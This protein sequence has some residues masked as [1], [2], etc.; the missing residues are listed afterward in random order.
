MLYIHNVR[1]GIRDTG[2]GLPAGWV[3][4]YP[5]GTGGPTAL[6]SIDQ[7]R[8]KQRLSNVHDPNFIN[9]FVPFCLQAL[10][11]PGLIGMRTHKP[12]S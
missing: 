1:Y 8:H 2:Y 4:L 6:S 10:S 11:F 7:P 3:M 12:L 9:P 5:C